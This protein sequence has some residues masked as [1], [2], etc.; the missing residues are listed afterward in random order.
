MSYY[1]LF[2]KIILISNKLV[3]LL[4]G[5]CTSITLYAAFFFLFSMWQ[6]NYK[7]II[8]VCVCVRE[9]LRRLAKSERCLEV[10]KKVNMVEKIRRDRTLVYR[11]ASC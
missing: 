7:E 10:G 8:F 11:W 1:T 4:V 2:R 3:W 5:F 9:C 6:A